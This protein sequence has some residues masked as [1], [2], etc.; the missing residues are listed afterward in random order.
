MRAQQIYV[1]THLAMLLA[2]AVMADMYNILMPEYLP[3]KGCTCDEWS[4]HAD[5]SI[6]GKTGPPPNAANSCAM[7]A[8]LVSA[9][10]TDPKSSYSGPWCYCAS[11][12]M[13]GLCLAPKATP[14]QI[15]LQ[16][17]EPSTV[18]VS[19]V[20]YEDTFD[21]SIP[22]VAYLNGTELTGV[23]HLYLDAPNQR[24]YTMH[25]VRFPA[26]IPRGQYSYKVKSGTASAIWSPIFSFRAPYTSGS[27]RVAIY[28]DM[29]NTLHNNMANL[30]DDCTS[31]TIDALVHMGDHAYDLGYA[32]D[33]HGDAYM[34]AFQ[35]VLASCPWLPVIGNHESYLG[36]GHDKVPRDTTERYLNQTWGIVYG[37]ET[38]SSTT[39]LGSLLTKGTYYGVGSHGSVPSGTSRYNSVDIGLF[40]IV[41]L[42]LDP[43]SSPGGEGTWSLWNSTEG[44]GGPSAQGLWLKQDLAAADANRHNVP[45][46]IVTSHFPLHNTMLSANS[47]KSAKHYV[48]NEG[49]DSAARAFTEHHFAECPKEEPDC[50]TIGE[51]VAVQAGP[52]IP[53]MEKYSVDVYDAGH[54][55]SY[56]VS[57]PLKSGKV[58][59]KTYDNP[60]GIVYITEGNGGVPPT[61]AKNTISNCTGIC[62]RK[63]TG[64]AYGRF[65]ANDDKT[66][67][68]EHVENPT[69]K[70]T[71]TWSITKT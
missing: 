10:K 37:Q 14:E 22:P 51:L 18:V 53:I 30:H 44:P 62:R 46:I 38:D 3:P 34:N 20:T 68:Y 2:A 9:S 24:N 45:W 66:L 31:G 41:G 23:S 48:G 40:H 58:T 21:P 8:E 36:P 5:E 11:T 61:P 59:A 19:F 57:W 27:S 25:F 42:D 29:G 55:H 71:D 17:A 6:W 67:T 32:Q 65:I 39:A 13:P 33:R 12:G 16:L 35:P 47:K 69:G 49:E 1:A 43:G 64:G 70:V 4:K 50:F 7:P 52:L 63:G 56:E 28:G 54:V 15:N 60:T 26:L